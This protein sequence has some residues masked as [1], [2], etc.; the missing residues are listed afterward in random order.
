MPKSRVLDSVTWSGDSAVPTLKRKKAPV[1]PTDNVQAPAVKKQK[2]ISGRALA[3]VETS[4]AQEHGLETKP[5]AAILGKRKR[6]E[7]HDS[8]KDPMDVA[9]SSSDEDDA[10]LLLEEEPVLKRTKTESV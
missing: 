10:V 4:S 9:D 1:D 3:C 5:S 8:A 6:E 7:H 2:S